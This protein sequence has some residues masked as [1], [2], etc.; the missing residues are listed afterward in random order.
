M[1]YNVQNTNFN[2][3]YDLDISDL[4]LYRQLMSYIKYQKKDFVVKTQ[5]IKITAYG[6]S[7]IRAHIYDDSMREFINIPLDKNQTACNDLRNLLERADDF[8]GSIHLRKKLFGNN[9]NNYQYMSLIKNKNN[10]EFTCEDKKKP[11]LPDYCKMKF[12]IKKCNNNRIIKSVLK[13]NNIEIKIN[14]ITDMAKNIRFN[15][16]VSLTFQFGNVWAN[17]TSSLIGEKYYGV[18]LSVIEINIGKNFTFINI[19]KP[20]YDRIGLK[21]AYKKYM[22]QYKKS[23]KEYAEIEI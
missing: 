3:F 12:L 18:S 5:P 13:K 20:I 22:D 4:Q 19:G 10:Y 8:F 11:F 9:A 17:K 6:I 1:N 23:I 15:N 7:S 14:S 21:K 16:I 2:K